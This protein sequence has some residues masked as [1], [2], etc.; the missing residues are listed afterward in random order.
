MALPIVAEVTNSLKDKDV[1]FLAVNLQETPE[2]IKQFL[3]AKKLNISVGLDKEGKIAELYQ[4][5]GIPATFIVGKDGNIA[6]MH[7][8]FSP[9]LKES[10]SKELNDVVS[11]SKT[12]EAGN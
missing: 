6:G 8:G 1:V 12:K 7:A 4:V 9:D 3:D 2:Q 11:G 5:Q 10:F